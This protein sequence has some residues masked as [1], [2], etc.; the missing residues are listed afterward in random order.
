MFEEYIL[1]NWPFVVISLIL[2]MAGQ[3]LKGT[4]F[5]KENMVKYHGTKMGH[6]LWWGRK[7]MPLHPVLIGAGL[8]FVPGMPVP[9]F[10]STLA[11]KMTYFSGAG[12]SSTWMF[13]II[14][15]VAKEKGIELD[16]PRDSSTPSAP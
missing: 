5:T 6:I 2:A 1:P 15:Q 4:I 3:V 12:M 9:V 8:A 7:T 13:S 14:K 11:A 16:L 10:I